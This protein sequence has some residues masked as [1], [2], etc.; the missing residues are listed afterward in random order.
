M[1]AMHACSPFLSQQPVALVASS[2][3][4][5][6]LWEPLP[7][8]FFLRFSLL[9]LSASDKPAISLLV[10][11]ASALDQRKTRVTAAVQRI[12]GIID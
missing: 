5:V 3:S 7:L 4:F 11:A 1:S 10:R 2:S 8:F 12:E 9:S 6:A